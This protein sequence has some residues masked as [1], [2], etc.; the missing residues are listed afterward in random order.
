MESIKELRAKCQTVHVGDFSAE[1]VRSVSIYFTWVLLLL[2][3][4]GNA[5]SVLNVLVGIASAA[6]FTVGTWP[7]F[8]LGAGL[9]AVNAILDGCDGEVARYRQQSSLTGLFAD[10]INSIFVF[11]LTLFGM[12]TGLYQSYGDVWVLFVGFVAAWGFNAL[13]LVKTNIDSTLIDAMTLSK[14]RMEHQAEAEK[15]AAYAPFSEYLRAKKVW[16]LTVLD[17]FIVRQPGIVIVYCVAV[18][19]EIVLPHVVEAPAVWMSPVFVIVAG[20]GAVNTAATF[21]VIYVVLK[22]RRIEYSYNQLIRK[23]FD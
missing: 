12:A 6:V 5:V 13:R 9:F 7:F 23:L 17:F 21:A 20:Y 18:I 15:D 8:V 3:F 19:G 14:A 2:G 1:L 10:R 22:R 4:S 16:F 11:P